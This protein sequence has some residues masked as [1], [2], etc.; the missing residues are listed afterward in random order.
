MIKRNILHNIKNIFDFNKIVFLSG[1]R[2]V[3]KTTL[4]KII[5]KQFSNSIYFNWDDIYHQKKLVK[6][7]YFFEKDNRDFK[8]S[9]LVIFD[10]IHKYSKWKNYLKGVYDKYS[11]EYKFIVLG[12]DRLDLY[13]KGGDSLFGRYLNVHLFPFTLSELV[14][15]N[16]D[17]GYFK[18]NIL[19]IPDYS[20]DTREILEKLFDLTGFPEPYIRNDIKFYRMW[21]QSRKNLLIKEDIR[22]AYNIK[23]IS[24]LE[25][26]TQLLPE[27]IGSPLSINSLTEDV[28]VS[29]DT[30]KN[31]LNL[32][33]RFYYIFQIN[34]YTKRIAR[35]IKKE[36]K[37]YL[38]DW[39][40]IEEKGQRFENLVALHLFKAV[41]LWKESGQGDANLCYIRDKEKREVDF[42]LTE[43]NEP[44][45]LIECKLS[46]TTISPSLIY[47]QKKLKVKYAVQLVYKKNVS[48]KIKNDDY[49]LIVISADRWIRLLV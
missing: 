10:E 20:A 23:D 14:K 26:L 9:F 15:L 43:K 8:K 45:C 34:T 42:V 41:T 3:G 25:I 47:Y 32:L 28:G 22:D 16:N 5:S 27:K 44:V 6:D 35:S 29:F 30:V 1:A 11:N 49:D 37:V 39:G 13:V 46:D 31:W 12:S 48:K 18:N 36:K 40:E 33:T 17:Y 38:Y 7:P 24:L 19:N 21:Q 4:A 2:Q